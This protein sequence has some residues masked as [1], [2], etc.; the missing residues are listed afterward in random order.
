[1]NRVWGIWQSDDQGQSWTQVGDRPLGSLDEIKAVE[2]DKNVYGTVYVGF[3]GSGY[4]VGTAPGTPVLP[5]LTVAKA[6]NGSGTVNSSPAGISCGS[7]CSGAYNSGTVVTLT[8]AATAGSSFAG[9]SGACTGTG[10]CQVTMNAAKSVTATFSLIPVTYGLTVAKAGTGS[11]TVTSS[12][13]GIAC[14][15]DCSEAYNSGTVV[16]LSQA[17]AAGSSFAGWSGACTGTGSCQVTVDA[18]KSVTATFNLV[19]YTLTVAKAGTG[20]G[21]VTSSP[22][23]IS[24]G[25][26]CSEAYSP[27][28]VVTLSQAA[29]AG[30]SFAGWSG[31]CT[32][33]GSCQVTIDAAKSVTATFNLIPYTLTV[34]KAGTGSG[35]V[36]SSPVGISCGTDCS[37]AYGSGT[38]VTLTQAAAA[39]SSFAGWS[40]ACT[41]TGSCQVTVDA[42]KSVTATFSLSSGTYTLTVAKAGTGTGTVTSSPA[43]INCGA[44][45]TEAYSPGTVVTL[46]Q[47]APAGSYFVGWGGFCG[48]TG[49]CS[50]TMN[51]AKSVTAT[52]SSSPTL[53]VSKAG[54]GT[55]TVT[56]S[57]AGINCG[58][59]CSEVYSPGTVVTLTASP[60]AGSAFTGWSGF[61]G[62]TGS[63]Q[64]TMNAVK[65]VSASFVSNAYTLTVT[66]TGDG[67]GR[68]TSSPAGIDCGIDC[69]QLYNRGTVVT[70]TASPGAGSTFRGWS[71]A[72]S[73]T[74]TCRVTI[75]ATKNVIADFSIPQ[76][77]G[78][79]TI[80]PCRALDT[81]NPAPNGGPALAAGETRVVSLVGVCGIPASARAVSVNLT[82]IQPTRAGNLRLFPADVPLPLVSSL[83]YGAWVTRSNDA[84][85]GLSASGTLAVRCTQPSG[86]AHVTLDVNGYFE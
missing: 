22:V 81:R 66:N 34:A 4:A 45:C 41:G 42:A 20:A 27:G 18:A 36:T 32:G 69:D 43:G 16:T 40:G 60:A 3:A 44:D 55:G 51:A 62:G 25:A 50:V 65:W 33:T 74:A 77:G 82:V 15:A 79:Y 11:G 80:V 61:C 31:A 56:S 8:Q 70:L 28:T 21:T 54:D 47:T 53:T 14:G 86:T 35:T 64:V 19:P 57:P 52:F 7:D 78:F 67:S 12:P 68:V 58:A 1:V 39:G 30:S 48:G 2:G 76:P 38:V 85:A 24:C 5:V 26:D 83:N 29:A 9:W 13:A 72:C 75:D 23:G 71:G 84:I 63:C 6:G 59:D 73:G 49:S 46:T 10:S 17:A 37:E